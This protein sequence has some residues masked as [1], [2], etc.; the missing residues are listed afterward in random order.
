MYLVSISDTNWTNWLFMSYLN[1]E[2]IFWHIYILNCSNMEQ[3]V[4]KKVNASVISCQFLI[5]HV[6]KSLALNCMHLLKKTR[7][8]W[9]IWQT[10]LCRC[11]PKPHNLITMLKLTALKNSVNIKIHTIGE[12]RLFVWKLVNKSDA[13][14]LNIYS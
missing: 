6:K 3:I 4:L 2:I 14:N 11:Q 8:F 9:G 12:W 5:N 10:W 13:Y 1:V 7:C